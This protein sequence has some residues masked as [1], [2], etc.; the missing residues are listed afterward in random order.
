MALAPL[1]LSPSLLSALRV[2]QSVDRCEMP[3]VR[4]TDAVSP[5]CSHVRMSKLFVPR[6]KYRKKI[7]R[8]GPLTPPRPPALDRTVDSVTQPLRSG[9]GGAWQRGGVLRDV[10]AF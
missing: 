7:R 3:A 6:A 8:T 1:Y 5:Q 2:S 10:P 4:V 9:L